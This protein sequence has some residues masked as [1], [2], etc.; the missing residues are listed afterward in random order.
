MAIHVF[1]ERP[2]RTAIFNSWKEARVPRTEGWGRSEKRLGPSVPG[3]VGSHEEVG[4][5]SRQNPKAQCEVFREGATCSD[6]DLVRLLCKGHREG[7]FH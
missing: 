5:Y 6:P 2:S 1:K 3:F 4:F 7:V